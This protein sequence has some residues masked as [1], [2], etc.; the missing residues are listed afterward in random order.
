MLT[1]CQKANIV[2]LE[3]NSLLPQL[4]R[5]VFFFP[6]VSSIVL[7]STS[8]IVNK[9]SVNFTGSQVCSRLKLCI[10]LCL[11]SLSVGIHGISI[12]ASELFLL[13]KCIER[14]ARKTASGSRVFSFICDVY[15]SCFMEKEW[16]FCHSVFICS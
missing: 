2:I 6:F 15:F 1:N 13:N 10:V 9:C 4:L 16:C 5:S 12:K 11:F 8:N 3:N 7:Q 14:H